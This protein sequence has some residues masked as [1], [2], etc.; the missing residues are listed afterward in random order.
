M[1]A[2]VAQQR[3]Q[4]RPK[5]FGMEA[6]LLKATAGAPPIMQTIS[7]FVL[8]SSLVLEY[9]DIGVDAYEA[10]HTP[11][12]PQPQALEI[13]RMERL[14][15]N[16]DTILCLVQGDAYRI[17]IHEAPQVLHYGIDC[18]NNNCQVGANPATAVKNVHTFG[19]TTSVNDQGVTTKSVTMSTNATPV[20]ISASMRGASRV[21]SM[22][23]LASTILQANL[24]ATPPP[25]TERPTAID[26]AAM[27]FEMT[28]GV[29]MVSFYKT[30]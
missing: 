20:D 14:G 15:D 18:Y 21:V 13:L 17:D 29:G 11:H 4:S 6:P 25:E 9:Q 10:G 5:L 26:S 1:L 7:G 22:S 23:A 19:V 12:D 2:Q 16:S 30:N 24:A 28:V 3:V 8:R 27:G